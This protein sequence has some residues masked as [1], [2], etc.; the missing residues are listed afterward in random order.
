MEMNN[1]DKS[2]TSGIDFLPKD[3]N[4]LQTAE[5]WKK[6]FEQDRFKE[7]FEWYASFNDLKQYLLTYI[8]ESEEI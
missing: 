4:D 6:F 3:Q 7:G 5:Y 1:Q 8:K 2:T